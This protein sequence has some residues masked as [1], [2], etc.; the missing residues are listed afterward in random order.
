MPTGIDG[1]ADIVD[2]KLPILKS[3]PIVGNS[4]RS[5]PSFEIDS[6]LA[7]VDEYEEWCS[8]EIN[9]QWLFNTKNIRVKYPRKYLII[10]HSKNFSPEDRQILRKRRD[11]SII[12]YDELIAM[13]RF[14]LYRLK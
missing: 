7:Q 11:A 9:Q 13:A 8:Q 5:H 10:G 1:Y 12:T 2:F 6:A 14:Q 3:K 4:T